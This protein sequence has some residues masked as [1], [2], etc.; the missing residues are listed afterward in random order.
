MI[1]CMIRDTRRSSTSSGSGRGARGEGPS[2]E[3]I[4]PR[5]LRMLDCRL[6]GA[7]RIPSG[8]V[9]IYIRREVA[10]GTLWLNRVLLLYRIDRGVGL[11][12]CIVLIFYLSFYDGCRGHC[13]SLRGS[14]SSGWNVYC[15]LVLGTRLGQWRHVL[16][17]SSHCRKHVVRLYTGACGINLFYL[18]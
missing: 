8:R 4:I 12:A 16:C 11:E 6:G 17:F 18:L 10:V 9:Q 15:L 3:G 1:G 2:R 13:G 5:L 7:C 14:A